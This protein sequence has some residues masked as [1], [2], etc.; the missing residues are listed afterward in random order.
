M[1]KSSFSK[2]KLVNN[3]VCGI[4]SYAVFASEL[5]F[6][7]VHQSSIFGS[8]VFLCLAIYCT[9]WIGS[10][11]MI[12]GLRTSGT[13]EELLRKAEQRQLLLLSI[14]MSTAGL[15]IM[16]YLL[17]RGI[18]TGHSALYNAIM[19]SGVICFAFLAHINTRKLKTLI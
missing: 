8:L 14:F 15:L 16:C 19:A 12:H 2:N 5:Y 1:N 11:I 4:L 6:S 17:Y 3:I 10:Y 9:L 7:L 18:T 13:K